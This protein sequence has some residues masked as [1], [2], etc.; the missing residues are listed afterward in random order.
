MKIN[1]LIIIVFI[2]FLFDACEPKEKIPPVI[3]SVESLNFDFS[4]FEENNT[5]GTYY[6]YAAEQISAWKALL[7]DSIDI[8]NSSLKETSYNDFIFQKDETWLM[9]FDF[10][11][12]NIKFT[13]NFFGI[14][15][16]DTTLFKTFLYSD[17]ADTTLVFLDGKFYDDSKTGHWILNKPGFDEDTV[18]TE[19][20]FMSVDWYVDS[21]D[22]KEIKFTDNQ[23]GLSNLNYILYKDSTDGQFN[24][25][26]N[27]YVSGN[28]N[29]SIIEWNKS[30][31]EGRVKDFLHFNDE[32]WHCW[33]N[34]YLNIDCN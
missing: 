28:D 16:H 11:V 3:P 6:S 26:V 21:L 25:Y 22:Q 19:I 17:A 12:E 20:K 13:A 5:T 30:T 10:I 31:K 18:F 7:T 4:Y 23:I 15:E 29:Y 8:Q 2:F 27:I 1:K 9:N 34:N 32:N 33:D 14:I 24:A